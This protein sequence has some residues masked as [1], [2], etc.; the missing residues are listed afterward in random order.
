ML[1]QLKNFNSSIQANLFYFLKLNLPLSDPV[2]RCD[3]LR[4]FRKLFRDSGGTRRWSSRQPGRYSFAIHYTVSNIAPVSRWTAASKRT[5][6]LWAGRK[7]SRAPAMAF[8]T[9]S[10]ALLFYHGAPI[11]F[12]QSVR[13]FVYMKQ[14]ES[15]WTD[16]HE[17]GYC[18]I[19]RKT[20]RIPSIIIFI[21]LF[22]LL[23][24]KMSVSS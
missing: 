7:K 4:G 2:L 9:Q 19:L 10:A 22:L 16:F 20:V 18:R 21:W 8:N 3:H 15:R 1:P 11:K 5:R 24:T 23:Y 6:V 12:P 13:L 14:L 17:V